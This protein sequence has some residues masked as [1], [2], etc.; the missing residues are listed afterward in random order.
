[1]SS[2]ASTHR[3]SDWK[4]ERLACSRRASQLGGNFL[5]SLSDERRKFSSV[6]DAND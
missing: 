3:C 2:T 1:M 4:H 6:T 5:K